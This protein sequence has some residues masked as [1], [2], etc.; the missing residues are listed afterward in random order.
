LF[1]DWN[2]QWSYFKGVSEPS[3]PTSLWAENGFNASEWSAGNAPFSYGEGTSGTL[4]GD[5]EGNYSTFYLRKEFEVSDPGIA[6]ELKISVDYDDGFALWIN[7]TLVNAVNV[8]SS[9]AYDQFAPENHESG[10]WYTFTVPTV[11]LPL[12]TGTNVIAIQGFNVSNTSTDFYL[13]VKLEG[14]QVL[15]ETEP[16][17]CDIPS[18]FFTYLFNAEISSLT[19]GETVKYTLDGSDPRTS[20]TALTRVT[21]VRVTINPNSTE[22]K[23]GTTGAVI[24]RASKFK[25][26]FAPSKPVTRTYIFLEAVKAQTHPGGSWPTYNI[27]GQHIDLPMDPNITN[28]SRFKPYLNEALLDIPSISVVTDPLH[29]FDSQTGIYVNAKYHGS[30]W[31]RPA[32]IE[33]INPDGTAGFNIDAGIRIRGGWSR[34]PEFAKHA[35]RLFFRSEYGEGKLRFPLFED[36]GVDEFDKIDLRTSQNYSWSKGGGE[37]KHNTMNRDV[38]SRDCQGDMNQ[39]YTR[40]R[41]YHL[42]LNGLYWGIYQTQERGEA[43]FAESYF[44]GSKED[45]DVIK[46][47]IGENWNVYEIEATDG[48]TDAWE[49]VWKLCQ[50][51]FSSNA[52]YYKL[53]GLSSTGKVDTSLNVWVDI[54]NLIDYMLIIFYTGNFDAPVS[55]FSGNANPNNF[56][57]IYN[58][59]KKREGFRFLI[60]D[61]EHTLLTDPVGPGVGINENRVNIGDVSYQRMNVTYFGKFHP[62]WLHHRLT[63]NEEYRIRFSDRVYKH[64]FNDGVFNP[65]SC[66]SRFRQTSDQLKMAIIAES[67]RWGDVGVWPARNKTD[68]WLPAVN[69]VLNNYFP[70][71]TNIVLDQLIAEDLYTTVKPPVFKKDYS[72]ITENFIIITQAFDLTLTNPNSGGSVIYTIDGSDPRAVGGVLSAASIDA[73]S[74]KNMVVSPGMIV[75]ARIKNGTTWSALNEINFYNAAIFNHLKVTELNYNPP[76]VLYYPGKDFEFIELK[77]TGTQALDLSG[78]TFTDGVQFTFPQG[79]GLLPQSFIVIASNKEMFEYYYGYPP[80]FELSGNFD[81]GGEKIELRT[82]EGRVVISFTYSN[83]FPWPAEAD[84]QGFSLVAVHQN[85]HG[86]PDS[87]DYWTTS[88]NSYGSPMED[89]LGSIAGTDQFAFAGESIFYL[90]PNPASSQISID[91]ALSSPDKVE[92]ELFDLNGRL[93]QSLLNS[94]LPEGQHTLS[95]RLD[96]V[97]LEPGIYLIKFRTSGNTLTKK[98]MIL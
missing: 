84:G 66:A 72:E 7:G 10:E 76:D 86:N 79:T 77:N 47:D 68:D 36:E 17:T 59:T 64:F 87:A 89:D 78:F 75:K 48:N 55:K 6:N 90:Y 56:F 26:G 46:V 91:F 50:A 12:I 35:F 93:I 11:D 32:N 31:E 41:Y 28:D 3:Q 1:I 65:D 57:A 8:P 61:G 94:V 74:E 39:P 21:P 73:G 63:Q 82:A 81:N 83:E 13:D 33:L 14:I 60:H 29:L 80:D 23:R 88:Y 58:R 49:E 96:P 20:S 27:N 98:M 62:Q 9:F 92:L 19:A 40:S 53:L 24:L 71:R 54:D 16:V 43:A 67:A 30:N 37:G 15:P 22:G 45:Y 5:M 34:H 51:G 42:Y 18:G 52:N 95:Y 2:A 70:Y 97:K 44:G 25:D 38:F 4:L 85:A 69:R